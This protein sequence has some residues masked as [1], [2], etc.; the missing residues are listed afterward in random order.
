VTEVAKRAAEEKLRVSF[1]QYKAKTILLSDL[2]DAQ[3]QLEQA[4]DDFHQAL[5]GVWNAS[6]ELEQAL[7]EE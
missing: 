3:S 2:L 5:L 1:N 6:A 4:N 7:G